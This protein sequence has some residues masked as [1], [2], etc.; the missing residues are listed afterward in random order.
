MPPVDRLEH[1]DRV[2]E[3]H[4]HPERQPAEGHDV[5]REPHLLHHEEGGDHGDGDGHRDHRGRAAVPEE[6]R[7][8]QDG[9]QSP[10]PGVPHH[11]R[12]SALDE[13]GLVEEHRQGEALG[14]GVLDRFQLRADAF[15]HLDG[16]RVALLE[17]ADLDALGAALAQDHFLVLEAGTDLGHV[18]EPDE[19]ALGV[20]HDHRADAVEGVQLVQGADQV[21]GLVLVDAA[22]G[23][24]HVV[25]RERVPDL[26]DRDA[27][28]GEP[29]LVHVHLDLAYETALDADRGDPVHRVEVLLEVLLG[30]LP[31]RREAEFPGDADPEDRV[32]GR[33][34]A[35][36]PGPFGVLREQDAVELLPH[37]E[38]GEVHVGVPDEL[39]GHLRGAGAGAGGD[40]AQPRNHGGGLLDG[41]GHQ[42]LHLD[43]GGARHPGLDRQRGIGDL[44]EQVD[45][46]PAEGHEPEDAG[47]H[48][49]HADAH[50]PPDAGGD[51]GLHGV[52]SVRGI[53]CSGFRPGPRDSAPRGRRP[54]SGSRVR[55]RP[56]VR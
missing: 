44:R 26:R 42:R 16:V 10:L 55:A 8:H 51:Q 35:Q 56:R 18:P 1:H 38:P 48:G 17:D 9:E 4:A 32:R 6:E 13:P 21:A 31:D 11:L 50:R 2:V 41:P 37:V 36:Q 43:G 15:G 19:P 30:P 14:N 40:A 49:E 3:Q 34:E 39:E 20:L 28:G 24:V 12:D 5:Q 22:A 46:Q 53:S 27:V 47:G 29:A 33:V 52:E 54:R 23:E 7:D 45:R 25:G